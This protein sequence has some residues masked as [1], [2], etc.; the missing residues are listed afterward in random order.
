MRFSGARGRWGGGDLAWLCVHVA[1]NSSLRP[2]L[3]VKG[4]TSIEISVPVYSLYYPGHVFQLLCNA[5][6]TASTTFPP[7]SYLKPQT[8]MSVQC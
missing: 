8:G 2:R 4:W 3:G 7:T 1:G 5:A 6:M